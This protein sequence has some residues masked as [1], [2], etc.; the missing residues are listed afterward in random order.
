[1]GTERTGGSGNGERIMIYKEK[2]G[3]YKIETNRRIERRRREKK[4]TYK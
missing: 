1:L 3:R 2:E 4:I